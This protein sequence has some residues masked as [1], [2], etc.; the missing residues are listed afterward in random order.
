MDHLAQA[1]GCTA[2]WL[3]A[4]EGEFEIYATREDSD[5]YA[6]DSEHA[7]LQN[8]VQGSN[9]SDGE[10]AH[11]SR[12]DQRSD[13]KD[14]DQEEHKDVSDDEAP[15]RDAHYER[16]MELRAARRKLIADLAAMWTSPRG[17]T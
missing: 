3:V 13:A 2:E 16:A 15:V 5:G 1:R 6:S 10:N 12:S 14:D 4:I 9:D 7:I 11:A 8:D 17:D